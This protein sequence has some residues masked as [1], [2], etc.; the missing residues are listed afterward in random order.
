[1]MNIVVLDGHT[2]S[3]DTQVWEPLRSLGEVQVYDRTAPEQVV[4]RAQDADV[5][6]VNKV[7]LS[8]EVMDLLPRL[9]Y[10]GV[11]AT[12]YN[13]VD[14]EAARERG[15]TVCNVP[16]YSTM[17]VAQ[18]VFA[19]L[20]DI[21]NEVA[22]YTAAVRQGQWTTSK[23]FCF[24]DTPLVE[25][26]G[27][28][29]GIVGLGN[30]GM[31]VARMAQAFG[32]RVVAYSSKPQ[33]ELQSLGIE[34]VATYDELFSRSDVLSLHCPLTPETHHLVNAQRL[35]LMKHTAI[36]INTGRGPLVDEQALADA[37]NSGRLYAA[38]VDVLAEEPPRQG[39]PLISA[40][41]CR[42]TPHIAWATLEARQR[43]V[44]TAI[45]NVIAFAEGKPVNIVS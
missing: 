3:P 21:T 32:M 19:H 36:F 15:I 17:S 22:H 11:L 38:G 7:L 28:T 26:D 37:L 44:S 29:M 10:I 40:R 25:L 41:N 13:V 14:V 20:L 43:L 12:G 4:Q 27:R 34:H 8:R 9:R 6:L 45:E 39:S 23:D 18:M 1:M 16:A 31:A 30:I 35:A 33:S 42:I 2:T 5:V 24:Y